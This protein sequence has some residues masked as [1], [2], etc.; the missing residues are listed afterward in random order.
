VCLCLFPLLPLSLLFYSSAE[1]GAY[2]KPCKI[3]V[4]RSL[5]GR[6]GKDHAPKPRKERNKENEKDEKD[7]KDEKT[8]AL[9]VALSAYVL[10]SSSFIGRAQ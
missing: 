2:L 1:A 10:F 7:E 3:Y 4:H 5:L 6:I 8:Q 9:S